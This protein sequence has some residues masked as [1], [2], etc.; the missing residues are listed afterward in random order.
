MHLF[1]ESTIFV[2]VGAR[3]RGEDHLDSLIRTKANLITGT[4]INRVVRVRN[5]TPRN[6]V[7]RHRGEEHR[8]HILAYPPPEPGQARPAPIRQ[9]KPKPAIW[10]AP[11]PDEAPSDIA[12]QVGIQAPR[13]VGKAKPPGQIPN[14]RRAC[15]GRQKRQHLA[16]QLISAH[17][18]VPNVPVPVPVHRNRHMAAACATSC[19]RKAFYVLDVPVP[20]VP[21]PASYTIFPGALGN[22]HA[23]GAPHSASSRASSSNVSRVST[24]QPS[25][26][27]L[28]SPSILPA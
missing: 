19:S 18:R 1:D 23:F 3:E 13:I 2:A 5:R 17:V 9:P 20:R 22:L 16:L 21:I 24:S 10:P 28:G 14:G 6:R 4:N 11:A 12:R 8:L 7:A 25:H 15:P 27:Y 26:S